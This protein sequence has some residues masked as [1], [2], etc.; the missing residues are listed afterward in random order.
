M[1]SPFS[2]LGVSVGGMLSKDAGAKIAYLLACETKFVAFQ[3]QEVGNHSDQA[4]NVPRLPLH[5]QSERFT[6][7][8]RLDL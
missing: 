8:N 7:F 2:S 1:R 3:A 6:S 5:K 4:H